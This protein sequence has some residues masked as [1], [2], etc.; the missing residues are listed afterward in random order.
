MKDLHTVLDALT[1][2]GACSAQRNAEAIAIVKQMM[3]FRRDA[4][5]EAIESIKLIREDWGDPAEESG[6]SSAIHVIRKLNE[7]K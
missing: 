5:E 4:L 2:A 3:Q 1:S 7:P 6:M